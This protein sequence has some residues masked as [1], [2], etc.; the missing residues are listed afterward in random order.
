MI[1]P[2][3]QEPRFDDVEHFCAHV[4]ARKERLD[5]LADCLTGA[6]EIIADI[7]TVNSVIAASDRPELVM[8]KRVDQLELK[9]VHDLIRVNNFTPGMRAFGTRVFED[10]ETWDGQL[11]SEWIGRRKLDDEERAKFY[12]MGGRGEYNTFIEFAKENGIDKNAA[13][14]MLLQTPVNNQA[15]MRM[16]ILF[17]EL[18][19][20]LMDWCLDESGNRY[21]SID[22]EIFVAYS[23]MSKLVDIGDKGVIKD[24][25][26][27]DSWILCR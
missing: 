27:L 12:L 10:R 16:W 5:Y 8:T 19:E 4:A 22:E 21:K 3:E 14:E 25:G 13:L 24:S 15:F 7:D 20:N 17:P 2:T 6:V 9:G 18:T 23:I 11:K 26:E 1:D